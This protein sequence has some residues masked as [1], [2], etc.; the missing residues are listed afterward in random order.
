[1]LISQAKSLN[2]ELAE[3]GS[4]LSETDFRSYTP[5]R[6]QGRAERHMRF[7]VAH[8]DLRCS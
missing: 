2:I 8:Q 5:A 1:M 4:Q 6:Q 7:P 3:I